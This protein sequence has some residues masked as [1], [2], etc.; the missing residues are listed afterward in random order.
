VYYFEALSIS[1]RVAYDENNAQLADFVGDHLYLLLDALEL[2]R[3]ASQLEPRVVPSVAQQLA[4]RMVEHLDGFAVL[5]RAGCS[6]ALQSLARSAFEALLALQYLLEADHDRRALAFQAFELRGRI[7][8][9]E[10]RLPSGAIRRA[11]W[12]WGDGARQRHR[13][14]AKIARGKALLL[15]PP[16]VAIEAAVQEQGA[17]LP[18]YALFGGPPDLLELARALGREHDYHLLYALESVSLEDDHE[19]P[20]LGTKSPQLRPL[21]DPIPLPQWVLLAGQLASQAIDGL[22]DCCGSREHRARFAARK[23]LLLGDRT[24]ALAAKI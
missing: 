8:C 21:R 4:W 10:G 12:G 6:Q 9:W 17:H 23:E 14:Q 24:R 1:D 15:A 7:Q 3:A 5:T 2:V 19:L 16:F 22:L 13:L 20:S 11:R 18:W